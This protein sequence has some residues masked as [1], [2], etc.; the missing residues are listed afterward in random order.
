MQA[1]A[2]RA[3]TNPTR[4]YRAAAHYY[5]SNQLVF[6]IKRTCC[7]LT[8]SPELFPHSVSVSVPAEYVYKKE[9]QTS[10]G[11]M[12][13]QGSRDI[14]QNR[15]P[16]GAFDV[17]IPNLIWRVSAL[18]PSD[19]D[20]V[21]PALCDWSGVD[22]QEINRTKEIVTGL[23]YGKPVDGYTGSHFGTDFIKLNC[24]RE[25]I[26]I[27]S[28]NS[29][30]S[31]VTVYYGIM[32]RHFKVEVAAGAVDWDLFCMMMSGREDLVDDDDV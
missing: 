31:V 26:Y 12:S 22:M 2:R 17:V 32:P 13:A 25:C 29:I 3:R 16:T 21:Y 24:G 30:H 19:L 23:V 5:W 8:Q 10:A 18:S 4:A 1:R 15:A 6:P 9:M 14:L 7:G 27:R 28:N 20:A 11:N